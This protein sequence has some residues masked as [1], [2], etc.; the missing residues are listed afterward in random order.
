M[1]RDRNAFIIVSFIGQYG[2][3]NWE[4]ENGELT[5]ESR[6]RKIGFLKKYRQPIHAAHAAHAEQAQYQ[7]E[8]R[9]NLDR[10]ELDRLVGEK[11]EPLAPSRR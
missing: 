7:A 4:I 6:F 9:I 11:S 3:F 2:D 8:G 5:V 10:E 1:S